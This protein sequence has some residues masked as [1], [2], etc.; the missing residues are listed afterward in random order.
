VFIRVHLW[1]RKGITVNRRSFPYATAACALAAFVAISDGH[2]AST[3]LN[4]N[5]ESH[6]A[7]E[8]PTVWTAF[9]AD[10]K[11]KAVV[12]ANA[13]N[14][15][16]LVQRSEQNGWVALSKRFTS[17]TDRIQIEFDFAFST[18]KGRTLNLWTHEPH[19]KDASQFNLC[20]QGGRLMQFEGETRSW[21]PIT[22]AVRSSANRNSPVWHRLR[23]IAD[24]RKEGIDY[25]ISKPGSRELPGK[26]TAT[27]RTYRT[28]LPFGAIDIVSGRRIANDAWYLI[29]NLVITAGD[30]L[31]AP[32]EPA[33][34]V[35]AYA[36]WEGPWPSDPTQIPEPAGL[37]HSTIHR[38]VDNGYKF[39][40]GAALI[41]HKG[42]LF[43]NWANSPTNENGPE[44][45]LQGRRSTDDGKTWSNLEVVGPGFN[46]L[47]R[48]SHGVYHS[49][50]G[51]LWTFSSRFGIGTKGNKFDGLQAEAFVL[52]EQTD[53]W[54][55]RGIAMTNCWPYDEPVLMKNG[56]WITGGQDKDG[57]P[58]VAISRGEN[59]TKWDSVLI[60]VANGLSPSFA[61]TTV[62]DV[63]NQI[64]AVIRGG[65]GAAWV[66]TSDDFGRTWTPTRPSNYRM[67]RAKAYFGRLST[68]QIYLVANHTNRDTLVVAV[69]KPGATKLSQMWRIRHG[70]SVP[71]RFPGH[72]KGKQWSYPYAHEHD[73]KLYVG[74]SIGK[75]DCGL[76]VIPAESLATR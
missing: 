72:A 29:D 75:E 24:R 37:T 30:D 20:I 25:W 10:A 45:T 70:K 71:P 31:P 28:G 42:T 44:E 2:A 73:G 46:T 43:A 62:L 32:H 58:V 8:P 68:G 4:E 15:A 6:A 60:P 18:S 14:K 13:S 5:F 55:S 50:K 1:F 49:H 36:L 9:H 56:N 35:G 76:S 33:E 41:H 64:V 54:I 65:K 22:R 57:L 53:R 47:E 69:G 19:G 39:L 63:D 34:P 61:E 27:M 74:Y 51:T 67:P 7:G 40:H 16:L 21:E 17:P 38:P 12:A 59:F 26:P 3:L 11:P 66:S 52:D 48:H 23:V